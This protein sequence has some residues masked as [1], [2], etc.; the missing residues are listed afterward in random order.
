M[1]LIWLYEK[2]V[3]DTKHVDINN[4]LWR[5]H[6]LV[7]SPISLIWRMVTCRRRSEGETGEWIGQPVSVTWPQNI[8]F[9]EQ[10]KHC[11]LTHAP[12]LSIVHCTVTS[13]DIY[14]PFH[15]V[16][17]QS[18][19]FTHESHHS[20]FSIMKNIFTSNK[21]VVISVV[22]LNAIYYYKVIINTGTYLYL[23]VLLQI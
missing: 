19:V 3:C 14:V 23:Q 20:T 2:T 22:G 1:S 9:Y 5:V 12:W 6:N 17:R 21:Y 13:T 11:K 10:Y 8:S 7:Q 4:T 16:E 18:V 15:F